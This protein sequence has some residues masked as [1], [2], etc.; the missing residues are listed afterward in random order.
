MH[1]RYD[2]KTGRALTIDDC[3]REAMEEEASRSS[4]ICRPGV[5]R[6]AYTRYGGSDF[7]EERLS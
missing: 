5:G 6:F 1:D 4:L 2:K 7:L 3:E